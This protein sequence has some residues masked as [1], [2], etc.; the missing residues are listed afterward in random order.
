MGYVVKGIIVFDEYVKPFSGS[1]VHICLEEVSLQDAPSRRIAEQ[2]IRNVSYNKID[3]KK[4]EFVIHGQVALDVHATYSI[5]VHGDVDNDG[6][7]SKGD[8]ITVQSYP[9][10]THGY[11][12][13]ILI[14]LKEVK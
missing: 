4:I 2:V 14:T 9:V 1:T 3:I 11:P 12:D 13:N 10:L 5:R 7:I 6:K 8:L